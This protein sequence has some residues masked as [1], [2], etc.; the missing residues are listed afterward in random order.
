MVECKHC[1]MSFDPAEFDLCPY[2]GIG[3]EVKPAVPDKPAERAS[4]TDDPV[5]LDNKNGPSELRSVKP[6]PGSRFTR[7]ALIGFLFLALIAAAIFGFIRL[8]SSSATV[9]DKYPTIQEAINAAEDG[10]EIVV[11]VGVYRENIDFMGKNITLRST[12]PDDPAIVE[13][14]IIDGDRRGPVVSFRNGERDGAVLSGFT[15][16]GGG[17]ILISGGSSP[18]IEKCLIEGNT[19]E[20][21]A[22]LF[23]V[24][25]NPT[26]RGN[27]IVGN[28]AHVGGGLF[29]EESSPIIEGNTI[30]GNR[31]EMGSGMAIYSNSKPVV[32]DNV[33]AENFA[34]RLGGAIFITLNS[35]PVI[36]DNT[37]VGNSA[38]ANGGGFFIEESE[39]VIENN[40]IRGNQAENGGGMIIVFILNTN[41]RIVNN[42]FSENL[43]RRAGGALYLV[44]SSPLIEGN[45]FSDNV[46]NFLGGAVAIYDSA[47]RFVGNR[48]ENNT[49]DDAGRGGAIWMAEDS[50]LDISEPDDNIYTGNIPDNIFRE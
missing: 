27:I 3:Q 23:I 17:G 11:K 41:F 30:A 29:I 5:A 14:T 15:I 25:S 28:E 4:G 45:S 1:G 43:A 6:K 46:S 12:D 50:T 40:T 48:F 8:N 24:D 16:T 33:I 42:T 36:T 37:I 9:P 2:C 18:L 10:A 13:K 44:G 22:G 47:P 21:G 32:K 34:G 7:F 35:A 49:A 20:F 19:A 31:A 38:E 26:V 39:P